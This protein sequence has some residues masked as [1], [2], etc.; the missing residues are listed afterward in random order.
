MKSIM[1]KCPVCEKEIMVD[2][3]IKTD[4][5]KYCGANVSTAEAIH[6]RNAEILLINQKEKKYAEKRSRKTLASIICIVIIILCYIVI[7]PMIFK[8]TN[9]RIMSYGGTFI[10]AI[11]ICNIFYSSF[12]K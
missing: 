10:I 11:I 6:K 1:A 2:E 3:D 7:E 5:C 8:E 4:T 9:E 12:T